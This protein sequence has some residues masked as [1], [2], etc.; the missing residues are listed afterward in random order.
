MADALLGET[1]EL[2]RRAVELAFLGKHR[3]AARLFEELAERQPRD[4]QIA[5]KLGELRRKLGD[6]PGARETTARA[7]LLFAELGLEGKSR[8][9]WSLVAELDEEVEAAAVGLPWW[10]R[11][12]GYA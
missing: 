3:R 8:A 9:A 6:L 12:F 11:L 10:R 1:K 7:A 2:R 4:P 5:L